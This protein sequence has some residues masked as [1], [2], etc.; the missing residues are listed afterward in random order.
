MK[1]HFSRRMV[2]VFFLIL[3]CIVIFGVALYMYLFKNINLD[4]AISLH[5]ISGTINLQIENRLPIS[6]TVGRKLV[7]GQENNLIY[8]YSEFV[9]KSDVDYKVNYELYLTK[10]EVEKEI[11]SN[12]IKC[13]LTDE[14]N[15]P[16]EGYEENKIPSYYDLK[17]AKKDSSGKLLY[18]GTLKPHE[19]KILRLRIWLSDAYVISPEDRSFSIQI[20]GKGV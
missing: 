7:D 6:D 3:G 19:Q 4:A 20:R 14:N 9:V 13:Y 8:G 1:Q 2:R 5:S 16:V 11:K 18:R 15:Q 17:V 10:K 12:Y